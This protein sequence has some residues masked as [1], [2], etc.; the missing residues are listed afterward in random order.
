M[1]LLVDA[2]T[3]IFPSLQFNLRHPTIGGQDTPEVRLAI[4]HLIPYDDI[5]E[6]L[7]EGFAVT[8][9]LIMGLQHPLYPHS[10]KQIKQNLTAAIDFM[11][12]AGYDQGKPDSWPFPE[13]ERTEMDLIPFIALVAILA[14]TTGIPGI[15][16]KYHKRE[17]IN[18]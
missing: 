1:L 2:L 6:F 15:I 4:S 11:E 17:K 12:I 18:L 3:W 13:G 10:I 7:Y 16:W 5:I 8:N 14:L 9:P